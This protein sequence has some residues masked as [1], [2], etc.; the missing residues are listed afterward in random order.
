MK[1]RFRISW[2]AWQVVGYF[3]ALLIGL[4]FYWLGVGIWI[5]PAAALIYYAA[6]EA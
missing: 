4:V 5:I 1:R 2:D 3:V 6:M